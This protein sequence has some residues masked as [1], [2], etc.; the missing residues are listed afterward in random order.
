[1]ADLNQRRGHPLLLN[2][3]GIIDHP[4]FRVAGALSAY[5]ADFCRG[6]NISIT[7]IE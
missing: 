4:R 3:C 7:L 5:L 2:L 6:G 1:M